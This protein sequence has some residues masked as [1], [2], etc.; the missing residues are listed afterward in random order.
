M[1]TL[2]LE[3]R[4]QNSRPLS[5]ASVLRL[6]KDSK[7]LLTL[8]SQLDDVARSLSPRIGRSAGVPPRLPSRHLLENQRP[9]A[10]DDARCHVLRHRP[11]LDYIVHFIHS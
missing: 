11:V 5:M 10:E 8:H 3:L 9:G 7:L 1:K 4:T 6:T 2:N